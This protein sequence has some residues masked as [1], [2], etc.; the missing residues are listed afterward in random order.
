MIALILAAVRPA[1]A[2]LLSPGKLSDGHASLDGDSGCS[3]CHSGGK[4]VVAA[5]CLGCH[6]RLAARVKARAGLHGGPFAGKACESCHVEHNGRSYRLI[7]WPGGAM[8]KLDHKE[9]GWPLEGDHAFQGCLKCHKAKNKVSRPTFLG[10]GRDCAGCHKDPHEARFG[11]TCQGC[12]SQSDWKV[13]RMD[14][15][16]HERT[17]YPLRGKH[18]D[19][20]CAKCHQEPPRWKGIPFERCTS[21]HQDPHG[22]KFKQSCE[23]CHVVTGWGEI[24]TTFR[25]EHPRLSLAG[26]HRKVKCATCHDRGDTRPPSKGKDCVGCHPAVHEAKFGRRCESCHASIAWVD[27]PRAVG[28]AAHDR[29]PYPLTGKHVDTACARCHPKNKPAAQRYRKLAFDRCGACHQ[30]QH[31]GEFSARAGGECAACHTTG[32]FTPTTFGMAAHATTG[33]PLEGRHQAAACA[34][35]HPGKRPRLDFRVAKQTCADCHE[36][37]HGEQFATEMRQGGCASCHAPTDWHQSRID[38][39]VWPL[40]GAHGRTACARCHGA[41]AGGGK[42]AAAAY[43][44]VPRDCEGCHEDVHAGQFRASDPVKPCTTCHTTER[45]L[46]PGFDHAAETTYPLDGKHRKVACAG[47]HPREELASGTTAVRYR[48]GYRACKACHADP[49]REA[50]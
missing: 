32:G 34:R 28:L 50:P 1:A 20:A 31:K 10:L 5:K 17:R 18:A 30:D 40:T 48:L 8:E 43:R 41:V 24:A 27:L 22:G 9:T 15:F 26:G 23:T 13:A 11:S 4:Q 19:V 47:C 45:F 6:D 12:H 37:P 42:A 29:T 2:Q 16:D 3:S 36:N 46:L 14:R 49:H 33:F 7:R 38:H 25:R 44:G 35:C 39:S 21:C